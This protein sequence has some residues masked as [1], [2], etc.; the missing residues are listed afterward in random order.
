M[1]FWVESNQAGREKKRQSASRVKFICQVLY[2]QHPSGGLVDRV[3][4]GVSLVECDYSKKNIPGLFQ[5]EPFTRVG[6]SLE[7]NQV[8]FQDLN[9]EANDI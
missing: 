9:S 1:D 8:S 7:K 6:N 5:L 4:E 2:P 3:S